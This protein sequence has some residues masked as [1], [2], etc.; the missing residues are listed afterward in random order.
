M[1]L[2]SSLNSVAALVKLM[3]LVKQLSLASLIRLA[4]LKFAGLKHFDFV[5]HILCLHG[6]LPGAAA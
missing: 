2:M 5:F 3:G 4:C 1:N 6:V